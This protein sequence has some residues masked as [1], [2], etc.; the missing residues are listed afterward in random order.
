M[1]WPLGGNFELPT[2]FI[3]VVLP[4]CDIF[5][6]IISR[7]FK[8]FPKISVLRT[9]LH[10]YLCCNSTYAKYAT[11]CTRSSRDNIRT[12]FYDKIGIVSNQLTTAVKDSAQHLLIYIYLSCVSEFKN[13]TE[14]L[15]LQPKHWLIN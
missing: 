13:A 12:K 7:I 2:W 6:K 9:L 1:R 3:T 14:K 4:I 5:I 15:T 8:C 11:H 10:C